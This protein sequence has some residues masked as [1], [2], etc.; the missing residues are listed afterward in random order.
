MSE[1][2]FARFKRI[3]E[4]EREKKVR[5]E[6]RIITLTEEKARIFANM[7]AELGRPVKSLEQ[8]EEISEDLKQSVERDL[9]KMEQILK[10]E[11]HLT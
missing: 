9:L 10:E 8:A 7:E 3:V 1:T 6:E 4:Q 2:K 11:G 5:S